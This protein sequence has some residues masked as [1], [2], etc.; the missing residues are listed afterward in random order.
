MADV[1]P[2]SLRLQ[3]LTWPCATLAVAIFVWLFAGPLFLARTIQFTLDARNAGP[4]WS[5]EWQDSTGASINGKWLAATPDASKELHIDVSG[6]VP[7]YKFERLALCWWDAPGTI[8]AEPAPVHL[9]ERVLW[10]TFVHDLRPLPDEPTTALGRDGAIRWPMPR[11]SVAQAADFGVL[12]LL[13]LAASGLV[14]LN[15]RVRFSRPHKQEAVHTGRPSKPELAALILVIVVNAWLAVRAPML[16]CPD[17]MDYAVNARLLLDHLRDGHAMDHFNAWRMP[18]YSVFLAPFVSGI[19]HYNTALGWTQGF[20][21]VMTAWLAS[22]I[23]RAYLGGPWAVLTL[24]LVGLAPVMLCWSRHAMPELLCTFLMTLI[25]WAT[26]QRR[27]WVHAKLY[28]AILAAV[29]MGVATAALCYTRQN[30]QILAALLPFAVGAWS[31]VRQRPRAIVLAFT[32]FATTAACLAPWIIR[33][34]EQFG[35]AQF[36]IG[37]GYTTAYSASEA[38]ELD[39]NQTGAFSCEEWQQGRVQAN[40]T[41]DFLAKLRDAQDGPIARQT[42]TLPDWTSLNDRAAAVAREST[43]R[44]PDRRWRLSLRA[45]ANLLGLWPFETPSFQENDYWSTPLR[46]PADDDLNHSAKPQDYMHLQRKMTQSFYDR[47]LQSTRA[48]SGSFQAVAFDAAY[49]VAKILRPIAAICFLVGLITAFRRAEW[50]LLILGLV[51]LAHAGAL[52]FLLLSGIDRYQSPFI[53][54]MAVLACYGIT[55][56]AGVIPRPDDPDSRTFAPAQ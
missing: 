53:P 23:T 6:A 7:N 21:A 12:L 29:G 33:N 44:H 3:R 51:P 10:I 20:L 36:S 47:T 14:R 22:R 8:V 54:L 46:H 5:L 13:L 39:A 35:R 41:F 18:G 25:A 49:H 19:E 30:F 56:I 40:G 2:K 26:V 16:Y 43:A 32:V 28:W 1:P 11:W 9:R 37:A 48:W 34:H 27:L 31:F 17:S 42:A 52:S 45:F 24:L 50:S 55:A 15:L 38:H 4:K